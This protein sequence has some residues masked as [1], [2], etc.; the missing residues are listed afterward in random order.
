MSLLDLGPQIISKDDVDSLM[1]DL[2]VP[3]GGI[4]Y[5]RLVEKIEQSKRYFQVH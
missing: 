1:Q 2:S 3:T 4:N 5:H